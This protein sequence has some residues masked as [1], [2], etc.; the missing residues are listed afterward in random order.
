MGKAVKSDGSVQKAIEALLADF[1]NQ[2][3]IELINADKW[4]R[5]IKEN[6]KERADDLTLVSLAG[7]AY[8]MGNRFGRISP[9][10]KYYMSI[11]LAQGK[12]NWEPAYKAERGEIGLKQVDEPKFPWNK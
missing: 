10:V 2:T 5:E 7:Y 1:D 11:K 9:F 12:S 8:K 4:L 3:D 6:G